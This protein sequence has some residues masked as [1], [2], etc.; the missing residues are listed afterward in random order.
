M[1]IIEV[2]KKIGKFKKVGIEYK[3]ENCTLCKEKN[4][5]EKL[6]VN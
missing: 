3:V 5:K 4:K 2:V 6:Y 1:E